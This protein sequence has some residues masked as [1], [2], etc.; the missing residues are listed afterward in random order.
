MTG[1]RVG[2]ALPAAG[3][4]QRMGG[5]HKPF[6]D[7]DGEPVLLHALRP[8]LA[9]GDVMA[10]A[11]ALCPAVA[12]DPPGWLREL[13]DRVRL[14]AG[15]ASRTESVALAVASLPD[16]VDI[17]AVHD[18]ARPLLRASVL[19]ACLAV[20]A[21]GVGAVAG[22]PAIDTVKEVDGQ[23]RIVGTPDRARLWYAHTPQ[24]FPAAM[25]RAAYGAARG[26]AGGSAGA[27]VAAVST[28]D[29]ALVER[30]G[31]TVQVVD[32][33]GWNLKVT[34]PGDVAV[35]EAFLRGQR[36]VE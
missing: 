32:D 26:G 27:G 17:I 18:A 4:G 16:D 24:V 2:V 33:G 35:A 13:D 31:G 25:I 20:A 36:E 22:C 8:F 11:V 14:L 7:L 5:V 30:A 29:A 23:G 19:E 10:I 15:G 12:A 3:T 6:L 34:R 1:L 9:R 28:D 21:T